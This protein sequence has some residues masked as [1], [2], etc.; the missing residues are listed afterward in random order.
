MR[1]LVFLTIFFAGRFARADF[2]DA[3]EAAKKFEL[4]PGYAVQTIAAEPLLENPVA[5]SMDEKGRI[6]VAETHRLDNAVVDIT[7][8]TNW[9]RD[10]LSFRLVSQRE[11]FLTNAFG[12]NA[13]ILTRKS[14]VLRLLK[15][16]GT[17]RIESSEVAWGGFRSVGA[18]LMAGVLARENKVWVASIPSLWR[19]EDYGG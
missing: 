12:T 15:P 2:F 18:G 10:D 14:E 8:N 3:E 1:A 5:F 19:L 7:K 9:L 6:W 16:G 13:A 17:G 4:A 11:R